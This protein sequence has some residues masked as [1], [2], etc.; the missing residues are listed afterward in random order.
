MEFEAPWK[1][2]FELKTNN[3]VYF[4]LA[5]TIEERDLWVNGLNRIFGVPV[6]DPNFKP[7]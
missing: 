3:R 4:L 5:P 2:S 6:E 7:M 1:H